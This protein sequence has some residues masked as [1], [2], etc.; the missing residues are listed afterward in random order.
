[1]SEREQVVYP[2]VLTQDEIKAL[3]MM[4]RI[5]HTHHLQMATSAFSNSLR[6]HHEALAAHGVIPGAP[7]PD[8]L[9]EKFLETVVTLN[10]VYVLLEFPLMLESA[11]KRNPQPTNV[12]II[13]V[14]QFQLD[15]IKEV[16]KI[17][18]VVDEN[19]PNQDTG[20]FLSRHQQGILLAIETA[21]DIVNEE[22]TAN[23]PMATGN[24]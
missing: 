2:L 9:G 11:K 22:V 6:I 17:K 13:N 8:L 15:K 4:I 24:N 20:E 10:N 18:Y 1:M 5:A 3:R 19:G 14:S 12:S 16:S 23:H 7:T 21:E